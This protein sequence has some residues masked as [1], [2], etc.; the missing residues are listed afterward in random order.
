MNVEEYIASGI[1]EA[2]VLQELSENEM[3][4]VERMISKYPE[5]SIEINKIEQTLED[6]AMNTA[7]APANHMRGHVLDQIKGKGEAQQKTV[8]PLTSDVPP[9]RRLGVFKY[10]TAASVILA[11]VSSYLAYNYHQEWKN[12]T[13]ELN[14]L[15]VQNE[16]IAQ[17]SYNANQK[18][19][20]LEKDLRIVNDPSFKNVPLAGT[21]N[22]PG[23]SAKVYW[24]ANTKELYLSVFH[25]ND[26][27][28]DKQY[29][30]WAI[31]DGQPVDAGVFDSNLERMAQMK[32]IG[33]GAA[34]FAVTIEP[35]GGSISPSLETMQVIGNV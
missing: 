5:L 15:I 24:K 30:L 23:S 13:L 32:S 14:K 9:N 6:V 28:E 20:N 12:T 16:R 7:V 22:A 4:E 27:P 19:E 31:I 29:Q 34:A 26:L 35:K 8:V 18:I 3:Q 25:M 11:I 21:E 2:Y 17:N 10:L 1:L 33:P